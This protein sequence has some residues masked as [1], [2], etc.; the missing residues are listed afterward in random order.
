MLY[1]FTSYSLIFLSI[2]SVINW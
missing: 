2:N 1:K